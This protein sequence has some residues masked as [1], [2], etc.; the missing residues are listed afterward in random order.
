M[1]QFL[2]SLKI[3]QTIVI[4]IHL[5]LPPSCW[6]FVFVYSENVIKS[7]GEHDFF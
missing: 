3:K 4:G 1:N 6:I 5:Y 2:N 7:I